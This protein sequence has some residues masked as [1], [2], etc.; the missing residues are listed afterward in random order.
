MATIRVQSEPFDTGAELA[1]LIAGRTDIGGIG[2]FVGVVRGDPGPSPLTALTLEHYPGMTEIGPGRHRR[3]SRDPLVAPRLH[4]HPPLRP[5]R[6][7]RPDRARPGRQRPPRARPRRHR[8]PD[9]LAQNPR[10]VLEAR[11]VPATARDLG[12]S[13]PQRRR[14]RRPLVYARPRRRQVRIRQ[15]VLAIIAGA[16]LLTWPALLN[17]YPILFSDTGGLLAMGLEPSMGWDKPWVYGPLL[18]PIHLR[19]TLWLAVAAQGS[20][21]PTSS[22]SPNPASHRHPS[23]DTWFSACSSLPA[24]PPPGSRQRSCP[25]SSPR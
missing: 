2:C 13:P 17:H 1:R 25:T 6:P 4:A 16:L 22:G 5:P 18:V 20:W 11:G 12:R 19:T 9:R 3:R 15:A 14:S 10:P 7:R 23:S 24:P 21:P 8:L